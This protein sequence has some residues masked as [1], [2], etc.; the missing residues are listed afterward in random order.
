MNVAVSIKIYLRN[1]VA[2]HSWPA[3]PDLEERIYHLTITAP[4]NVLTGPLL[5]VGVAGAT[6]LGQHMAHDCDLLWP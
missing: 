6:I 5:K 1:Q 2:G 3:D 4:W